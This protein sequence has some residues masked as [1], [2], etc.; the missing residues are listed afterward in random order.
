VNPLTTLD[1]MLPFELLSPVR[2]L[3]QGRK[4][5][6]SLIPSFFLGPLISALAISGTIIPC[7]AV[8]PGPAAHD[9]TAACTL[10]AAAAHTAPVC[11]AEQ[12]Y[13]SA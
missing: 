13:S 3:S 10:A 6:K 5:R 4:S 8:A 9:K 11:T 2:H 12:A 7:V 1:N